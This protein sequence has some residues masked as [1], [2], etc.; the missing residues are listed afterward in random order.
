MNS[1]VKDVKAEL[2][3]KNISDWAVYYEVPEN[4]LSWMYYDKVDNIVRTFT[5]SDNSS[6]SG[7]EDHDPLPD[8]SASR[9]KYSRLSKEFE[10]MNF[11][12]QNLQGNENDECY[13][14]NGAPTNIRQSEYVRDLMRLYLRL[15][16]IEPVFFDQP[17]NDEV[18]DEIATEEQDQYIIWDK[19]ILYAIKQADHELI[20][21]FESSLDIEFVSETSKEFDEFL[22]G[23]LKRD[24][25]YSI[26]N[27]RYSIS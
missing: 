21:L 19:Y 16:S 12:K 6:K 15:P 9:T 5:R 2:I 4:I 7:K 22:K 26:S 8:S 11:E 23:I 10:K 18:S 17:D 27:S 20:L 24:Y 25:I 14:E 1:G 3:S 13:D